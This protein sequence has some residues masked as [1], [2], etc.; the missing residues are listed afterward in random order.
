[1]SNVRNYT[2]K[3]L[4][5]RMKRTNGFLY[6][7]KGIHIIAVRSDEDE[8]DKYDDKLYLFKGEKCISVMS[9]TT[10]SG[11]YG[12]LNFFKWNTFNITFT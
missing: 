4:I 1:M 9:C 12:L 3:Q 5:G 6:I 11:K 7:P 2:D 8:P 10:N